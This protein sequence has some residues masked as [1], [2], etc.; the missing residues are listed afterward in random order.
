MTLKHRQKMSTSFKNLRLNS[1]LGAEIPPF[2]YL[3]L[4]TRQKFITLSNSTVPLLHTSLSGKQ[5]TD[6]FLGNAFQT[7]RYTESKYYY[8]FKII[9]TIYLRDFPFFLF[10]KDQPLKHNNDNDVHNKNNMWQL[11]SKLPERD[12]VHPLTVS[13][14]NIFDFQC[15]PLQIRNDILSLLY[16]N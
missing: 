10:I 15:K 13:K 5:S 4:V 14:K 7:Q 3:R 2:K 9:N 12:C 16:L 1:D 6:L 11:F 8:H